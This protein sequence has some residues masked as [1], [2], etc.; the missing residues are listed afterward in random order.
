MF[1]LVAEMDILK[2]TKDANRAFFHKQYPKL[3]PELSNLLI[4]SMVKL[5]DKDSNPDTQNQ[6]LL[7]YH[8]TIG[9]YLLL[10]KLRNSLHYTPQIAGLSLPD[11]DSN[12][13]RQNQNL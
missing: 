3:H 8:Y 5:P 7:Y 12:L 4:V 13:G 1:L 9:Q 6:N 11:Q 2:T 10:N